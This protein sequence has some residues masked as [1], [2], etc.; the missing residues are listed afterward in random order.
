MAMKRAPTYAPVC[1]NS[2]I[3]EA[4]LMVRREA[5]LHEVEIVTCSEPHRPTVLGDRTQLQQVV[6]NLALNAIQAMAAQQD[7]SNRLTV[8]TRCDGGR[9]VVTVADTGPGIGQENTDRIFAS[10]Y[11]T[12]EQ[13]V[14]IGLSICRSIVEAHGGYIRALDDK[15]GATFCFDLPVMQ[16]AVA[17]DKPQWDFS[18]PDILTRSAI[19]RPPILRIAAPR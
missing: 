17:R 12:K 1:M 10:F 16:P 6:I 2:L 18:F 3:D 5:I 9:L 15:Q 19:V 8:A 13:G 7:R 14:G 4:L 11:T